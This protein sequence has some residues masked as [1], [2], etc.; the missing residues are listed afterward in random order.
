MSKGFYTD[1]PFKPTEIDILRIIGS[2]RN[3]WEFIH[4]H[5]SDVLKLKGDLKFYGINYGWAIRF[6]K[7]GKSIAALYPDKDRFT[8]QIILNKC[9]VDSALLT[10][11]DFKIIEKIR[12]QE[13]IHEGKWIYLQV[14]KETDL[15]DILKLIDIRI[16]IK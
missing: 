5:L 14:D 12:V 15:N 4:W 13:A 9:Q 7:S 10:D 3:N 16:K 1:R 11:M 6:K 8:V 2:A